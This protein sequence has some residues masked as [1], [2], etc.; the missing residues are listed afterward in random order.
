MQSA[1]A[2]PGI[3]KM[4]GSQKLLDQLTECNK[5][6]ESVQK[7]SRNT[8]CQHQ[9]FAV[10]KQLSRRACNDWAINQKKVL[11]ICPLNKLQV[12]YIDTDLQ[13]YNASCASLLRLH[14]LQ[15]HRDNMHI[16]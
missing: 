4:C 16:T 6:L 5:L 14:H 13:Q 11:Q 15:I 9:Q 12:N 10:H 2:T 7:V 1:K 3:L 8:V